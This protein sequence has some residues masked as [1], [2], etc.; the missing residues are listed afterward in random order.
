MKRTF[1]FEFQEEKNNCITFE[2]S[3]KADER[4]DTLVE[5]NIPILSLNRS[6]MITLAKMLIK[7]ALGSYDSGFHV[8][9]RKDLN[10]DLPDRLIVMLYQG[11]SSGLLANDIPK[12]TPNNDIGH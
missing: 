12:T 4:L 5:N 6:A 10:A 2:Y 3:Q 1:V 11:E 7:M 8:H 9:F